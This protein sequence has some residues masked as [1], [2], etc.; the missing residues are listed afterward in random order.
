M[1]EF[2]MLMK[3]TSEYE[4]WKIYINS[5][6]GTGMFR[7][8]SALGNVLY[9]NKQNI[10]RSCSITGFIRFEADHLSQIQALI[11]GNPVY[12]SGGEVELLELIET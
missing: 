3:G 8:G 1:A 4:D 12:E 7:G 9:A 2:M 6:R 10:N 5:L 11:E